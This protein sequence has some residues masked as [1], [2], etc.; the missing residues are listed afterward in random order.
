MIPTE[1]LIIIIGLVFNHYYI[2]QK[3]KTEVPLRMLIGGTITILLGTLTYIFEQS[4]YGFVF[5][6]VTIIYGLFVIQRG[7]GKLV[8]KK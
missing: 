8:W 1:I 4:I 6:I 3:N 2:L 7:M 5:L